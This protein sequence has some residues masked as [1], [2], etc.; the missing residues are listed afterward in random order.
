MLFPADP[1]TWPLASGAW[2]LG[3]GRSAEPVWAKP[4]GAPIPV[5]YRRKLGTNVRAWHAVGTPPSSAQGWTRDHISL[6]PICC[7]PESPRESH[8]TPDHS[9]ATL[10]FM[11]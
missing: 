5:R 3:D 2:S 9:A 8:P 11:L 7:V 6:V 4:S 10:P 1:T